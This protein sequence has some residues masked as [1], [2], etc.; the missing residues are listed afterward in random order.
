MKSNSVSEFTPLPTPNP[1]PIIHGVRVNSTPRYAFLYRQPEFTKTYSL[2]GNPVGLWV[3]VVQGPLYTRY[4]VDPKHDCLDDPDSCRGTV[5]IPV[6]RPY[7]TITVRDNKTQ[8]IVAENGYARE[9][10][11]DTGNYRI[12]FTGTDSSDRMESKNSVYEPG[13]RYLAIYREGEFQITVEGEYLDVTLSVITGSSPDLLTA[14][15]KSSRPTPVP[16]PPLKRRFPPGLMPD[17]GGG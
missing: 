13:P 6:N 8:A 14:R 7:M 1:Y 9:Y 3:N 5:E 17:T 10:S 11:S 2:S 16:S 15:E 12:V 4:T